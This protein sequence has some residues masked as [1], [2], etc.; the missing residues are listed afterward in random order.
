[1]EQFFA[2]RQFVKSNFEVADELPSQQHVVI[3]KRSDP[4]RNIRNLDELAESIRKQHRAKVTVQDFAS[5]G[6]QVGG[7]VPPSSHA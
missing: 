4:K 7:C 1:M 6:M 2:F 5:I 3:W